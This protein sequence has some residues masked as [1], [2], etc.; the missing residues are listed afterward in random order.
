MPEPIKRS[1]EDAQRTWEKAHD[2]AIETYGEGRRAHQTAYAALK[3]KYQKVG[4]HW[5]PK[6]QRGPSDPQARSSRGRSGH[7]HGGVDVAGSSKQELLDRARKLGVRGRTA[8]NKHELA[9][10][11]NRAE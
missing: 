4:D 2:S 9:E 1:P 6:G 3:H 8:M 10:A 11:I 7:T 5:E